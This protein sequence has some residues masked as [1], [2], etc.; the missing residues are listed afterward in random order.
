MYD[1]TPRRVG[2]F[3][4]SAQLH[5]W[6]TPRPPLPPVPPMGEMSPAVRPAL[7]PGSYD[8]RTGRFGGSSLRTEARD[9]RPLSRSPAAGSRS[10]RQ[11]RYR[12]AEREE[13]LR[14]GART[15]CMPSRTRFTSGFKQLIGTPA[16]FQF[17]RHL[18]HS[19]LI[20]ARS[21][22]WPGPAGRRRRPGEGT[23]NSCTSARF[24]HI[25]RANRIRFEHLMNVRLASARGQGLIDGFARSRSAAATRKRIKIR[26]D[27][28]AK[29][30]RGRAGRAGIDAGM[31]R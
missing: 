9:P 30:N 11:V 18:A 31:E 20:Q 19:W 24:F 3:G 1:A 10:D 14:G 28:W 16:P 8:L 21:P 12:S 26:A 17:L 29:L 5:R 4:K 22:T 7:P 6:R 15:H 23:H 25:G 27:R 13:A 2:G